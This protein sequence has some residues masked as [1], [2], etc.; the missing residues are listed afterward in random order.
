M[1][2]IAAALAA[3][4]ARLSPLGRRTWTS[5]ALGFAGLSLSLLFRLRDSATADVLEHVTSV[6]AATFLVHGLAMYRCAASSA[7]EQQLHPSFWKFVA[8]VSVLLSF[9]AVVGTLAP[10]GTAGGGLLA[11]AEGPAWIVALLIMM[12]LLIRRDAGLPEALNATAGTFL[13]A[14]AAIMLCF[15]QP[16]LAEYRP[17][18]VAEGLVIATVALGI[19]FLFSSLAMVLRAESAQQKRLYEQMFQ[20]ATRRRMA[21]DEAARR[22]AEL[23]TMLRVSNAISSAHKIDE[24]LDVVSAQVL[25]LLQ[26]S[27]CSIRLLD[28]AGWI[29]T[30]I[31]SATRQPDGSVSSLR[32]SAVPGTAAQ[33]EVAPADPDDAG[34]GD[35]GDGEAPA[36]EHEV[37]AT[38]SVPLIAEGKHLGMLCVEEHERDRTFTPEETAVCQGIADQ[39]SMGLHRSRLLDE[40]QKRSGQLE[41]LSRSL[42]EANRCLAQLAAVDTTTGVFNRRLLEVKLKS[43]IERCARHS[44]SLCIIMADLDNFKEYNDLAGHPAGDKALQRI[45]MGLTE[46]TRSSDI[47][48]R[49]G[50]DEFVVV[51]PETTSKEAAVVAEKVR[52]IVGNLFLPGQEDVRGGG[53]TISCG[54]ACWDG[55]GDDWKALIQRADAALY[56]AKHEGANAVRVAAGQ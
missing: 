45:A 17:Q 54:V 47:V 19:W 53:V 44:H 21:E 28:G 22:N 13:V 29:A 30:K 24:A 37:K 2:A 14:G 42:R 52:R 11:M 31:A 48:G 40:L 35:D 9:A 5:I 46:G 50:G 10:A 1:T 56:Q 49:F 20:D 6:G 27:R 34:G 16:P 32:H 18:G 15:N 36:A 23:T 43:E 39:V 3:V 55:P 7:D 12:A 25:D 38:I 26:T 51:L 4:I 33:P 8:A 41:S